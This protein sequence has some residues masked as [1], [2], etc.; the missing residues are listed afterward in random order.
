MSEPLSW[1]PPTILPPAAVRRVRGIDPDRVVV[2]ALL[3]E[4][5]R[6]GEH[7]PGRARIGRAPHL[8]L[9]VVERRVDEAALRAR[10]GDFGARRV[11][12]ATRG[13]R[14]ERRGARP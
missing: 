1:V 8:A 9:V 11:A 5:P 4:V 7:L 10:E 3:A 12:L 14:H 2:V 13:L 6:I